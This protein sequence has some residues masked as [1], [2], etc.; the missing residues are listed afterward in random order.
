MK[1][2]KTQAER[3]LDLDQRLRQVQLKAAVQ[4]KTG[5]CYDSGK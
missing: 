2:S 4:V 5:V 1:R 3:L